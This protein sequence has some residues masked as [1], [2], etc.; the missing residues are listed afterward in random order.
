MA[1]D[2]VRG[3]GLLNEPRL[4]FHQLLHVFDCFGHTPDLVR[5]DHQDVGR[6]V[7]DHISREFESV[8]VLFYVGTNLELEVMEAG[9]HGAAQE[10]LHLLVGIP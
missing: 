10:G 3:C 7:P 5:V 2:I 4:E 9:S 1:Q 6:V 8:P